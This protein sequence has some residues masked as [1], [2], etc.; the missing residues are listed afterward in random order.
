MKVLIIN[1]SP[2][3]NGNSDLLC[4]AFIRGAEESGNQVEKISLREKEVHSSQKCI[5]VLTGRSLKHAKNEWDCG[6]VRRHPRNCELEE[7]KLDCHEV[8]DH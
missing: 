5:R 7:R 4:D 6:Q 3:V 8:F 2:R 1:G